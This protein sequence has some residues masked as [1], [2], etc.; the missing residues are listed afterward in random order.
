MKS[1]TIAELKAA[2]S[3]AQIEGQTHTGSTSSIKY[4]RVE[5]AADETF[6]EAVVV[7]YNGGPIQVIAEP[8]LRQQFLARGC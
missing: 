7:S 5:L 3:F 8:A 4:K 2:K 1:Y 6:S